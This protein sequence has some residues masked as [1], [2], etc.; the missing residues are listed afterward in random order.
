MVS[1]TAPER[2]AWC[3]FFVA[4]RVNAIAGLGE[5][6]KEVARRQP[7]GSQARAYLLAQSFKALLFRQKDETIPQ[8]QDRKGRTIS[9]RTLFR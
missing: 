7:C 1:R 3:L 8:A 2:S 9:Q 4:A 5:R 6:R